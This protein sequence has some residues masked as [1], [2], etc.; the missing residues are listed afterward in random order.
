MATLCIRLRGI[1]LTGSTVDM[2]TWCSPLYIDLAMVTGRCLVRFVGASK[3]GVFGRDLSHGCFGDL[4]PGGH[5]ADLFGTPGDTL[6]R[7]IGLG[8][9]MNKVSHDTM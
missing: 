3:S 4:R 5:G 9:R 8:T 2:L 6:V 7:G 1:G